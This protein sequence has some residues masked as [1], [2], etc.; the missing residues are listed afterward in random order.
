[1]INQTS[2]KEEVL[3]FSIWQNRKTCSEFVTFI[4]YLALFG[5]CW[6]KMKILKTQIEN[7][8]E[9]LTDHTFQKGEKVYVIDN[10]LYDIFE[11]EIT[12]INDD[13]YDVYYPDYET[14]EIVGV[15]R[16][17][18]KTNKNNAEY[19]RQERIRVQK[20]KLEERK[21]K[22]EYGSESELEDDGNYGED[23]DEDEAPKKK[24]KPKKE[25]APKPKREPKPK[26]ERI[27]KPKKEPKP[28]KQKEGPKPKKRRDN[29]FNLIREA[30]KNGARDTNSFV[31][32]V[33][34]KYADKE[35]NF[36]A[37][38]KQFE[39]Y[40]N[41]HQEGEVSDFQDD[42]LDDD[43]NEPEEM[44]TFQEESIHIYKDIQD[45]LPE[46]DE[47]L[48]PSWITFDDPQGVM[49]INFTPDEDDEY[50]LLCNAFIYE[51]DDGKK[52]LILNGQKLELTQEKPLTDEYFYDKHSTHKD[53]LSPKSMY[54]YTSIYK[55]NTVY[56]IGQKPDDVEQ[57]EMVQRKRKKMKEAPITSQQ[58]MPTKS[59]TSKSRR[60][61]AW[62]AKSLEEYSD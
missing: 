48:F 5:L 57:I 43:E 62:N 15:E 55:K 42:Y 34:T 8:I 6:I 23:D 22:Q 53:G 3:V 58:E 9:R 38:S 20:E 27:I 52:Y 60:E 26:K 50:N 54:A 49:S 14:D 46:A 19:E 51:T 24:T 61:N 28:R 33:E 10:N 45:P 25:K 36:E 44:P 4:I 37:L 11:A 16:L 56:K 13:G 47:I 59:Y 12:D 2:K 31:S 1:M 30:Y 18:P 32:Y 35:F 21:K 17:L 40:M 39:D 29:D 7:K 41:Q